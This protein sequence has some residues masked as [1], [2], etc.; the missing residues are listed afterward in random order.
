MNWYYAV[1]GQQQ[2]PISDTELDALVTSGSITA[3][4]LVWREG[5]SEWQPLSQVRG[6]MAAPGGTSLNGGAVCSQCQQIFPPDQVIRFG[7]TN[8]CAACKPMFVQKL[9]EGVNVVPGYLDYAGFGIR[10]AAKLLDGILLG[11]IVF[12]PM[13]VVTMFLGGNNPGMLLGVQVLFQVLFYAAWGSFTIFF[14]GRFGATPGKM[15]CGLRVVSGDGSPIGYGRAT[16]RFFAEILSVW[17]CCIGY[18]IT[19]FDH[20][21]RSLHD[22]ICNTRVVRK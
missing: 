12:V 22:H 13:V 9:K 4:T 7:E 6:G 3:T 15:A 8:V 21:K 20:Q 14:I 10:F 16:G 5:M 19:V 11:M 18:L 17:V 1:S 2:G